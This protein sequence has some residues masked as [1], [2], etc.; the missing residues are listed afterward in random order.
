LD[1]ALLTGHVYND[2]FLVGSRIEG[3][4]CTSAADNKKP[5]WAVYQSA[6]TIALVLR[7]TEANKDSQTL[8]A[9]LRSDCSIGVGRTPG[10]LENSY[11]V[12]L[13]CKKMAQALGHEFLILGHSL[14]GG[15]AQILGYYL[16]CSF[17]AFN[18]PPVRGSATGIMIM[19]P[20]QGE[21]YAYTGAS[22]AFDQGC[23]IRASNDLI[24]WL[25]GRF[26][27][28][29]WRIQCPNLGS[30]KDN[31]LMGVLTDTIA[32]SPT[33]AFRPLNTLFGANG[34]DTTENL[35]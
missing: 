4:H 24:S 25:S 14:G 8:W 17:A 31:H 33:L 12:A 35:A 7:G 2:P 18:P 10:R 9:D 6:D 11:D 5:D 15:L 27:G 28:K 3:W 16:N 32:S 1:A 13:N 23:V 34:G 30:M 29:A 22:H 19:T 26:V 20:P 21:G